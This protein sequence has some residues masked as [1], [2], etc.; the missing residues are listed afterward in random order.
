MDCLPSPLLRGV[1]V[2]S[3]TTQHEK[4]NHLLDRVASLG[5]MTLRGDIDRWIT[6]LEAA[7]FVHRAELI[8]SY[9]DHSL[10]DLVRLVDEYGGA[11]V[12]EAVAEVGAHLRRER[13]GRQS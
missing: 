6:D 10:V 8:D 5:K 1:A 2:G 3:P 13:I 11:R 4:Q 9:E 7:G 12:L